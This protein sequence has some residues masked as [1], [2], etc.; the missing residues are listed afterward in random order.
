MSVIT[1]KKVKVSHTHDQ[2]LGPELI[3]VY[4][5]SARRWLSVIHPA[6]GCHYFPPGH[7]L[8]SQPQSITTS[9]PLAGTE[10]YCLVTEE[11]KCVNNLSKVFMPRVGFEPTTCWSQ[12]Q[13]FTRCAIIYSPIIVNDYALCSSIFFVCDHESLASALLLI[14]FLDVSTL[15][16]TAAADAIARL[17][18]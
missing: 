1:C 9:V 11:N 4:R 17:E 13:R 12:V 2:A 8:S 7:Q 16:V 3:P 15:Y 14:Y 10:W 5:Q 18:C 6:V